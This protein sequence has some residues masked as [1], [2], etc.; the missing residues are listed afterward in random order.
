MRFIFFALFE[1]HLLS[2]A[3][4]TLRLSLI[5]FEKRFVSCFA[6]AV[7]SARYVIG[8][9]SN[10]MTSWHLFCM[11]Q[12]SCLDDA[13]IY[14]VAY[15]LLTKSGILQFFVFLIVA[16][17]RG[18]LAYGLVLAYN[19]CFR[20]LFLLVEGTLHPFLH[21]LTRGTRFL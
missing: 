10:D 16:S 21:I 14:R 11:S 5:V 3:V 13:Q 15:V 7:R 9:Y 8:R 6:S 17:A 12:K 2:S 20:I 18:T 19:A 1:V 4:T